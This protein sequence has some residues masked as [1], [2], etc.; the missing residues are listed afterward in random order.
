MR[1]F[2]SAISV[3]I[4]Q[5]S[6]VLTTPSHIRSL[7]SALFHWLR[8]NEQSLAIWLEGIALVA[9]FILELK[10]YKRQGHERQGQQNESAAQLKAMQSQADAIVNS[11]RAW[12]AA[13]L[14]PSAIKIAGRF[15]KP[16]GN[17]VGELSDA[18]LEAREQFEYRLRITNMG[19]TPAFITK[20][21]IN[22]SNGTDDGEL[23]DFDLPYRAVGAGAQQYFYDLDVA[24]EVGSYSATDTVCFFGHISY[25]HVFSRNDTIK[26]PFVY[27]FKRETGRLERLPFSDERSHRPRNDSA[28]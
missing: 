15:Y 26:E 22:R 3:V 6:S 27:L 14:V 16:I 18:D 8:T 2:L 11:E 20:I 13:E 1:V 24:K 21:T 4:Q 17:N 19:K 5:S 10:E 7:F 28:V 9:I 12:L 25:Q 23:I